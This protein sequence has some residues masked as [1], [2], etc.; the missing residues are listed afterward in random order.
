[1][2]K[3]L[4]GVGDDLVRDAS[5][6]FPKGRPEMAWARKKI[7]TAT[8]QRTIPIALAEA[9]CVSWKREFEGI[10][11]LV[12]RTNPPYLMFV[13]PVKE[14]WGRKNYPRPT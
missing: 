1:M 3:R 6:G 2:R 12:G 4:K 7:Q 10:Q 11:C 9:K 5:D 13:C 8:R 14:L